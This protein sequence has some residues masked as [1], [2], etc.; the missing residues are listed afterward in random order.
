MNIERYVEFAKTWYSG[1]YPKSY[2]ELLVFL[3][4]KKSLIPYICDKDIPLR[5]TQVDTAAYSHN[6]EEILISHYIFEIKF[7]EKLLGENIQEEKAVLLTILLFN[8]F[9]THEATHALRTT[10]SI[11]ATIKQHQI[12]NKDLFAN[13]FQIIEDIHVNE[14][15][16]EVLPALEICSDLFSDLYFLTERA[17]DSVVALTTDEFKLE[18]T[19]NALLCCKNQKNY[20]LLE[21]AIES[22]DK[23]SKWIFEEAL[24]VKN[25]HISFYSR[26]EIVLSIYEKL[27]DELHSSQIQ[28]K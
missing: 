2:K 6:P 5:L 13:L 8:N 19:L 10:E 12:K 3:K 11:D 23:L 20:E 28:M 27:L 24:E 17:S 7:F 4:T 1:I 22:F 15:R 26:V 16:R 18:N 21:P 14:Y 9:V 25:V